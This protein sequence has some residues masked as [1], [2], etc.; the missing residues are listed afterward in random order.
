MIMFDEFC[1]WAIAKHLD[2]EDDD[3]EGEMAV[4]LEVQEKYDAGKNLEKKSSDAKKSHEKKERK[5]EAKI[6]DDVWQRLAEKLPW[7]KT[8]EQKTLRRSMF[9]VTDFCFCVT[10]QFVVLVV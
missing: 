7:Q 2:L 4:D 3:D 1:N 5:H 8:P 9:N 10:Q 6:D